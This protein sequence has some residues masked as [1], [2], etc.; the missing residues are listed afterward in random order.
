[1]SKGDRASK[2]DSVRKAFCSHCQGERNSDVLGNFDD[3]G[4]DGDMDWSTHWYLLRCCG[5]EHVFAQTVS[6]N[7]E[8]ID[9][10]YEEDGSTGG[11]YSETIRYWP[12]LAKRTRP[13]WAEVITIDDEP[14]GQLNLVLKELY[15]SLDGDLRTLAAIG[16]RTTFDVAT[17]LLGIDANKTFAEKLSSLVSQGHIGALDKTRLETLVDAGSASAHRGWR[18][19]SEDLDTMMDVLEHFINEA[20]VVP[21]MRKKLDAKAAKMKDVVPGRKSRGKKLASAAAAS[22]RA[23]SP[24]PAN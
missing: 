15:G 4:S 14:A 20:F 7:S 13:S 22:A 3:R 11:H 1:M 23:L 10:Y 19:K 16:I 21:E 5:C 8:D 24:K 12:A 2:A 6:T 9:Y 17:D 18:P